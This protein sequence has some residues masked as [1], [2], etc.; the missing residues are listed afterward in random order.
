MALEFPCA[1]CQKVLSCPDERVGKPVRCPACRTVVTAP[2]GPHQSK[3]QL[4]SAETIAPETAD[5]VQ[6]EES[7][8][9]PEAEAPPS[10]KGPALGSVGNYK[11]AREL[12]RGGMGAVYEA[13]DE[14]LGRRVAMKV[15]S[16]RLT[17]SA[18]AIARFEREARS[19]AALN[20]PNI[21][22]VYDI[23]EDQG[24]HY[25]TMEFIEGES[26]LDRLKRDGK[27]PVREA[28]GIAEAVAKALQYAYQNSFI[29]RDI[30]P[31]NV[32]LT[33]DGQ[34]KLADLGLAKSLEDEQGL[35]ATGT[36][37]GTPYYMAPE[38][39]MDAAHVDHRADIYALG[40]T[41]LHTMTGK[42]P[43][44]AKSTVQILRQHLQEPLPSGTDLG[45][46][47]PEE[48]EKLVRKMC[49]KE[50]EKRHAHYGE[51]LEDLEKVKE[52]KSP[53]KAAPAVPT[54]RRRI[55]RLSRERTEEGKGKLIAVIVGAAI[56]IGLVVL[57]LVTSAD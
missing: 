19:A 18:K 38:Q 47:L 42:R 2:A 23:G 51:L 33:A 10:E 53:G 34:V 13:V 56:V 25:F 1:N 52:G 55:D 16:K 35:T 22:Q 54:G 7:Q 40:I 21:V 46:E 36:A 6:K 8:P 20:H 43:Y 30:K 24:W 39:T 15:L 41:L 27:R 28:L 3:E 44:D 57:W 29:H 5:L 4:E 45:T 49:E 48:V 31:E 9:E 12:G 37:M 14:K 26:L 17:S 11:L 50:K 32:M